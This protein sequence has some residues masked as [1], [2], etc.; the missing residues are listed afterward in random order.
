[1]VAAGFRPLT[2]VGRRCA[3]WIGISLLDRVP[4]TAKAARD[5]A[6]GPRRPANVRRDEPGSRARASSACTARRTG[7]PSGCAAGPAAS[8]KPQEPCGPSPTGLR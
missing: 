6:R 4:T 7:P 5:A 3:H 1:A 2:R 8:P